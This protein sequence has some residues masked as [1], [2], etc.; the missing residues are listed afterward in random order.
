[1]A[2]LPWGVA[3][4]EPHGIFPI[5]ELPRSFPESQASISG[6]PG[7]K[8]PR[9]I[10]ILFPLYE[11][12]EEARAKIRSAASAVQGL[13]QQAVDYLAREMLCISEACLGGLCAGDL[14]SYPWKME[15]AIVRMDDYFNDLASRCPV[16]GTG[17]PGAFTEPGSHPPVC[18][19]ADSSSGQADR[20]STM[21]A[22]GQQGQ[23]ERYMVLRLPPEVMGR[24]QTT[25]THPPP[26]RRITLGSHTRS[27]VRESL[28]LRF[29]G[30]AEVLQPINEVYQAAEFLEWTSP[31]AKFPGRG[32]F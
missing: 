4:S 25:F 24:E 3:T 19:A 23:R 5:A 21:V 20:Q 15:E 9:A 16:L 31:T 14:G 26:I 7:E 2:E 27:V 32:G 17:R 6:N 8:T 12:A 22:R 30:T 10:E 13:A 1:M 28:V 18:L 11:L 29:G